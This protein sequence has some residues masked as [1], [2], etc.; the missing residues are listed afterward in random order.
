[1][2]SMLNNV[3]VDYIMLIFHLRAFVYMTILR[4]YNKIKFIIYVV[5]VHIILY[6][7]LL[8]SAYVRARVRTYAYN[9]ICAYLSVSGWFRVHGVCEMV[10]SEACFAYHV[11]DVLF[12]STVPLPLLVVDGVRKRRDITPLLYDRQ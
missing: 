6:T 8:E 3:K 12:G 5:G 1:M 4:V 7:S 2:F 9:Y 10:H 11:H